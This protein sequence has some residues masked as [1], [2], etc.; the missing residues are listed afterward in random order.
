[1]KVAAVCYWFQPEIQF[2]LVRTRGDRFWVFPKGGVEDGE[3]PSES[4]AREAQ[5]EAGAWGTVQAL[6]FAHFSY[7]AGGAA[8]TLIPAFLLEVHPST[9]LLA[10]EHAERRP[11]WFAPEP[12]KSALRRGRAAADAQPLVAV[13]DTACRL[14]TKY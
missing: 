13:I 5:E 7:R 10:P 2:L 4:A 1:M 14:L 12:A 8:S 6:P 11:T 3:H 9:R